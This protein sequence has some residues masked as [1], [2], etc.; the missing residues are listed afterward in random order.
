MYTLLQRVRKSRAPSRQLN[1]FFFPRCFRLFFKI[2]IRELNLR[3][4]TAGHF[5]NI[6]FFSKDITTIIIITK[7]N[8][9]K[10]K[11]KKEIK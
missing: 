8:N 3:K 7:I 4:R 10:E 1:F 5:V 9:E 6:F 2:L 11:K